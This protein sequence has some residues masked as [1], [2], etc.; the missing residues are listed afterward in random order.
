M[1][2]S[3]GNVSKFL[4]RTDFEAVENENSLGYKDPYVTSE[5]K[6]RD[7]LIT[8]LLTEYVEYYKKKVSH[9]SVCRYIILIPCMAIIVA[10]AVMLVI[11][12]VCIIRSRDSVHI[13][14]LIAFITACVSFISL[15]I[16]LLTI[17]TKYF[18]PEND[19]QYIAKIVETIQQNDL[20]NKKENAKNTSDPD[21]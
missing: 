16:G 21:I 12:S 19:E 3:A 8:S 20:E 5:Q 1:Q 13:T 10:F 15:I 17:V 6:Q 7:S 2:T 11:F 18:F 4:S 9:I 14:N